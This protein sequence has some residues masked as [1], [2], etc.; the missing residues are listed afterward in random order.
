M[1]SNRDV[2][3]DVGVVGS[4]D[5]AFDLEVT[6]R[7]DC[8]DHR[9]VA[10][11]VVGFGDDRG[12]AVDED[13]D[14]GFPLGTTSQMFDDQ[15]LV[16]CVWFDMDAFVYDMVQRQLSVAID[17]EANSNLEELADRDAE[18][19]ADEGLRSKGLWDAGSWD[20]HEE[21]A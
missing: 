10:W 2:P 16:G 21:V 3:I 5:S 17:Q 11:D 14:G 13:G 1:G 20:Q 15:Y 6:L 9:W 7:S 18:T 8:D 4:T 12:G 19:W